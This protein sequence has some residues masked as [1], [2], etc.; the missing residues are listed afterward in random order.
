MNDIN[1]NADDPELSERARRLIQIGEDGIATE[2]RPAMEAFFHSD[3]RVHGPNEV[4][5]NRQELWDYFAACRAAFDDFSATRQ[6]IFSDGGDHV[7]ARSTFRGIFNRPFTASPLGILEPTG[8]AVS[9]KVN[10][11]FRYAENGQV[12]E[13]WAQYDTLLLLERLGVK[14]V[15]EN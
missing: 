2:N 7:A 1:L 13:E 4:T 3:F 12:I 14:I 6:Q 9:Y 8:E 11:I 5:L 15:P 10:S